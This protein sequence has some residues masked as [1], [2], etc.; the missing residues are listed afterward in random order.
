VSVASYNTHHTLSL[1]QIATPFILPSNILNYIPNLIDNK[2]S[3]IK[4][5]D[6]G[7]DLILPNRDVHV[8]LVDSWHGHRRIG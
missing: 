6:S 5:T 4:K 3:N 2:S 1:V 7:C 8:M